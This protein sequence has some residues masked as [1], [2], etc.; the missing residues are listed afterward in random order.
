MTNDSFEFV[1]MLSLPPNVNPFSFD[2]HRQGVRAGSPPFLA[3]EKEQLSSPFTIMWGSFDLSAKKKM[4]QDSIVIVHTETGK[5]WQLIV[6]RDTP[7][8]RY[9]HKEKESA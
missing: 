1:P 2:W 7:Y 8:L 5:R 6:K 3:Q 4:A 9:D